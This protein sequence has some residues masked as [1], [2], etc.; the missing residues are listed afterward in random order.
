MS[1][2]HLGHL[3]GELERTGK[4]IQNRLYSAV[5]FEGRCYTIAGTRQYDTSVR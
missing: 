5:D 3:F 2:A 1:E 4:K